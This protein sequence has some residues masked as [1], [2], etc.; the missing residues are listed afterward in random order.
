[1]EDPLITLINIF[2]VFFLVLLNGFFVAAEFAIVSSQRTKLNSEQHK[3]KFGWKSAVFLCNELELSLSSTQLGITIA[4]LILGWWGEKSLAEFSIEFFGLVSTS[5][6]VLSHAFATAIAL[7]IVT[8]LH[9]VLGELA[10]KSVAIR[11]PEITLRYLAPSLTLFTKV[12]RPILSFLNFC[13]N[14]FLKIFGLTAVAE[15]ERVHTSGELA[16]LVSHSSEKGELDKEEEEMLRGVFNFGDTVAR[17]VM[18]P[19]TDLVTISTT[20]SLDEVISTIVESGYSRLPVKGETVDDIVGVL[21][22]RDLFPYIQSNRSSTGGDF[23]ICKIAREPF[24][25]PD[26]KPIDDLLNELKNRKVHMAIVL[27]EHG[28]VDGV[29]TLE[30]LVEEIVGEIFDE[31]DIAEEDIVFENNGDI[32]LDASILVGEIN[33]ELELEIPE[34]DY[35]TLSGFMFTLLGRVPEVGDQIAIYPHA[36]IL[37]NGIDQSSLGS[38][39]DEQSADSDESDEEKEEEMPLAIFVV[40]EV[41]NNRIEHARLIRSSLKEKDESNATSDA[42]KVGEQRVSNKS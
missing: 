33:S 29:V 3:K 26:T 40:E 39:S 31:S 19:R 35:D 16:M 30:D 13:A 42:S 41:A 18:T 4:S 6:Y 12:C 38:D 25:I 24:F 15:S 2:L 17:E 1:M 11:Y 8:F 5:G 32:I 20:S 10:A 28:G 21:L 34:G 14:Q 22:A 7:I 27:D 23:D 37:V 36:R 9:V